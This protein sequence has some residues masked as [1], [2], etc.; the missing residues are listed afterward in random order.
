M[1][2]LVFFSSKSLN[3]L[4]SQQI[5]PQFIYFISIFIYVA[6]FRFLTLYGCETGV[7]CSYSSSVIYFFSRGLFSF[8]YPSFCI[9]YELNKTIK[10]NAKKS[11]LFREIGEYKHL[12]F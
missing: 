9:I 1:Q 5:S 3:L 10:N 2:K 7:L 12:I 8:Y 11:V 6:N 4:Y